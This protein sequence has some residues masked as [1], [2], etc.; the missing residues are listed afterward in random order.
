MP[1]T[2]HFQLSNFQPGYLVRQYRLLEQ[3]GVGGQGI[4][5][6]AFDQVKNQIVAIKFSEINAE[7]QQKIDDSLFKRQAE[8]LRALH[9][10]HVLPLD[11]YGLSQQIRYVVS[12]YVPGGSLEDRLKLGELQIDE[13]LRFAL[14]IAEALDYL[15]ENNLIHRDLKPGNI[16]L[17]LSQQVYLA[18]FGLARI[19]SATTQAMHTGRGTP[20]YAPPEQHAMQE[21]TPKSD[22]YSLGVMLY[23]M[24]TGK[25]PWNGEKALGV[26][27]LYASDE[28]P[29]P[30]DS[31]LNLP[32]QLATLLR[33]MTAADPT[34]RPLSASEAVRK[35]SLVCQFEPD[36]ISQNQPASPA[37]AHRKNADE[38]IKE[39]LTNRDSRYTTA[40]LNLTRFAFVA[41]EEKRNPTT[42]LSVEKQ[43]FLVRMALT[44]DYEVDLWWSKVPDP[45]HRIHA[46]E[47][48]I[49]KDNPVITARVVNQ[50]FWDTDLQKA[51]KPLS[52]NL[53]QILLNT[54]LSSSDPLLRM[55]ILKLLQR[56]TQR[57]AT[58]RARAF[59]SQQDYAL[60]T[61]AL[62]ES[63]IGEAAASLIGYLRSKLAVD[64]LTKIASPKQLAPI[65]LIIQE[66]AGSL[67]SFV[68]LS[69]RLS[70]TAEWS[71]QRLLTQPSDLLLAYGL[72]FLG[73]LIGMGLNVYLTYRL[74][75]FLDLERFSL[76]LEHGLFLGAGFGFGIFISKLIVERLPEIRVSLRLGLASLTGGLILTI[77]WAIYSMLF[78]KSIPTGLLAPLGCFLIAFGYA[79]AGLTR[80]RLPKILISAS[81]MTVVLTGSWIGHLALASTAWNPSPLV[82]YDYSWTLIQVLGLSVLISLCLATFPSLI[83]LATSKS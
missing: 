24:F 3:I 58:W 77:V 38:L 52:E 59:N 33:Q 79:G 82:Y 26:Q 46:A 35:I 10:P 37:Q 71:L 28:L 5:W 25:L 27:Q 29:N 66:N 6:S 41:L 70:L 75:N 81:V 54:A 31:R 53:V 69:T 18:D 73:T 63:D 68:K 48:L 15:H 16:L 50:L 42:P 65:L 51:H 30:A 9:H 23:E 61:L 83:H 64:W 45:Q 32:A 14:E 13:I 60:A 78:L 44:F 62:E 1:E 56:L 72:A 36:Q 12:P 76:A 47:A 43:Q 8:T 20:P 2:H 11:D 4:V 39:G 80:L 34:A 21:I 17:D 67:P 55:Q 74:P 57:P 19:I 7:T 22:I 40:P 49:A